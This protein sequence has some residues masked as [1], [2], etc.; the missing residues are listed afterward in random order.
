M[1]KLKE[2]TIVQHQSDENK[3]EHELV[4]LLDQHVLDAMPMKHIEP[5]L[6][7]LLLVIGKNGCLFFQLFL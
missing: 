7:H 1:Q 3:S 4:G 5:S 2:T 6:L